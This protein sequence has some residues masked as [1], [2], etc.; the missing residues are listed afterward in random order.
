ML[1]VTLY[2]MQQRTLRLRGLSIKSSC[3]QK[4]V[5]SDTRSKAL[6]SR[7]CQDFK[8]SR[9]FKQLHTMKKLDEGDVVSCTV[10]VFV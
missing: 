8:I 7:I 4:K 10:I 9:Y 6:L 2:T 3:R 5:K 1:Y